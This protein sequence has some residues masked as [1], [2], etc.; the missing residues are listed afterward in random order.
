MSRNVNVLYKIMLLHIETIK[1][2]GLHSKKHTFYLILV[3][4]NTSVQYK[5]TI[6]T[7]NIMLNEFPQ[8]FKHEQ[9]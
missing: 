1:K 8:S 4:A 3:N 2:L 9:L 7:P 5:V 6:P